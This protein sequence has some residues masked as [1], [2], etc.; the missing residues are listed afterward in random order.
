[1][2]RISTS[3]GGRADPLCDRACCRT[4]LVGELEG[5]VG[6]VGLMRQQDGTE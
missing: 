6:A 3:R 5:V 4:M 2:V 1:M